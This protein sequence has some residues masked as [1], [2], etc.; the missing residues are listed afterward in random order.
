MGVTSVVSCHI[1]VIWQM[2]IYYHSFFLFHRWQDFDICH[3][4]IS[5][6]WYNIISLLIF[7]ST[8]VFSLLLAAFQSFLNNIRP[9][10]KFCWSLYIF[11]HNREPTFIHIRK[12][13]VIL[14]F[15]S[16]FMMNL[17]L[18]AGKQLNS[19][20]CVW[21][22]LFCV[23]LFMFFLFILIFMPEYGNRLCRCLIVIFP[24]DGF[25]FAVIS[26]AM[27]PETL[28]MSV[29]GCWVCAACALIFHRHW[30]CKINTFFVCM[31][32]SCFTWGY[33]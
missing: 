18:S 6:F 22:V 1:A 29:Y 4:F 11:H 10:V 33:M 32:V 28:Y 27:K 5:S 24:F 3:R 2:K 19:L 8:V 23:P 17:W 15:G 25:Y 16:L 21:L 26:W 7:Y 30:T 14:D 9:I 20:L 31:F 12:H 13:Y